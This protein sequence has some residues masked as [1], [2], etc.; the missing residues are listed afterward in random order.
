MTEPTYEFVK[1]QGW[2]ARTHEVHTFEAFGHVI[3][4][5]RR[6]PEIGEFYYMG[7]ES[8]ASIENQLR[9]PWWKSQFERGQALLNFFNRT[10]RLAADRIHNTI[11]IVK[12]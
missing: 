3:T 4:L 2:V 6:N 5:E 1:G 7:K 9:T 8:F 11:T 10:G 12:L